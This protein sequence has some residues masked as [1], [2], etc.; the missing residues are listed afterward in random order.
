MTEEQLRELEEYAQKLATAYNAHRVA[1]AA[2]RGGHIP[3]SAEER[4]AHLSIMAVSDVRRLRKALE[5]ASLLL[6]NPEGSDDGR[7]LKMYD[8]KDV[9]AIL[10]EVRAALTR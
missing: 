4:A 10:A 2:Q 8:G 3:T 9:Q 6:P 1:R 7:L 5:R